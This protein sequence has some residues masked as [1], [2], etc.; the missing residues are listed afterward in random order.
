MKLNP[1]CLRG[2]LLTAEEVCTVDV[3]WTYSKDDHCDLTYLS[4]FS[5]SEIIYHIRQSEAAG[6]L[7]KVSYYDIDK[8]AIIYDLT[9]KGHEFLANIREDTLWQKVLKKASNASLPILIDVA[10]EIAIAHFLG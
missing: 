1:D 10:K 2:I 5:H 6:L 3:A 8:C 7:K 4:S 9:P